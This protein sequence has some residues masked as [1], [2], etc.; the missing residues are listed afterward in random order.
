[1]HWATPLQ[2][3]LRQTGTTD[4]Q[5]YIAV[6]R[7]LSHLAGRHDTASAHQGAG[8][9]WDSAAQVSVPLPALKDVNTLPVRGSV[10]T[11]LISAP[12]VYSDGRPLDGALPVIAVIALQER[13]AHLSSWSM[14]ALLLLQPVCRGWLQCL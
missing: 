11:A 6:S 2:V 9:P 14:T 10:P 7:C 4:M 1:M 8:I 3:H 13:Q 12:T 5:C